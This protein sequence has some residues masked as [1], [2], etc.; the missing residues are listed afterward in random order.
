[1]LQD[2]FKYYLDKKVARNR[3]PLDA[4]ISATH[5]VQLK[6]NYIKR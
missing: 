3:Q 2:E 1:M 5:P 4:S 6:N